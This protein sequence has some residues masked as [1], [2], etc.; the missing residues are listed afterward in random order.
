MREPLSVRARRRPPGARRERCHRDDRHRRPRAPARRS[1]ELRVG[2]R[3][4]PTVR[5]RAGARAALVGPRCDDAGA[6]PS[7]RVDRVREDG[8]V[9]LG[10]RALVPARWRP[11]RDIRPVVRSRAGALVRRESAPG[12][13]LLRGAR[14][15]HASPCVRRS[16]PREGALVQQSQRSLGGASAGVRARWAGVRDREARE[17]VRGRCRR[18]DRG[19]VRE[20][21]C[22]G[23]D[24]S[25]RGCRRPQP[26]GQL[27]A[28]RGAG[29]AVRRGP[30]CTRV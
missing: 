14:R 5:L 17:P 13:G 3:G 26:H 18:H 7:P 9:R 28:R 21:A 10:D 12:C 6:T 1:E 25:V 4:L 11:S 2:D 20:G 15:S 22:G 27:G 23:S 30:V 19:G 8:R 16:A 24:V 29:G